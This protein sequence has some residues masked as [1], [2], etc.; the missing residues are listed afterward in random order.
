VDAPRTAGRELAG[1]LVCVAGRELA[2]PRT[3]RM[4][5]ALANRPRASSSLRRGRE[6]MLG[7]AG[8]HAG[9]ARLR[10]RERKREGEGV[11]G[12]G[13]GTMCSAEGWLRARER[14]GVLD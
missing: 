10:E 5:H 3:A 4:P 6:S 1:P 12:C 9:C 11:L 2:L 14:E 7:P 13:R 8:P